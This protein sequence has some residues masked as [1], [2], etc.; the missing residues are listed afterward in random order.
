MTETMRWNTDPGA[1]FAA[2][3][4]RVIFIARILGREIEPRS[5]GIPDPYRIRG[6]MGIGLTWSVSGCVWPWCRDARADWPRGKPE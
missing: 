1:W 5:C 6:R 2:L 3:L 4:N